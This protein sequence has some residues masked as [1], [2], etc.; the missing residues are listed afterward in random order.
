MSEA[1]SS[2]VCSLK[3]KVWV[4]VRKSSA[5]A[6]GASVSIVVSGL[7]SEVSGV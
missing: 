5:E 4:G 6:L 1:W 3:L 7:V 2:P